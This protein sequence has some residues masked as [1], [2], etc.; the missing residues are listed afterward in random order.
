[1][2]NEKDGGGGWPSLCDFS[3]ATSNQTNRE[4]E[5]KGPEET[6][7]CA[8]RHP[9]RITGSICYWRKKIAVDNRGPLIDDQISPQYTRYWN[10]GGNSNLVEMGSGLAVAGFR[11]AARKRKTLCYRHLSSRSARGLR[12][13]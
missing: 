10:E 8:G 13:R 9:A 3:G 4:E 6:K 11:S 7:P 2:A 5:K 12:H 1:V